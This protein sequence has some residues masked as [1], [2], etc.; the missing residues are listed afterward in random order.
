MNT[1]EISNQSCP[2]KV[3]SSNSTVDQP[4]CWTINWTYEEENPK[5]F[6]WL[7]FWK[8]ILGW[9][10]VGRNLNLAWK[11]IW[12]YHQEREVNILPTEAKCCQPNFSPDSSC[13]VRIWRRKKLFHRWDYG[14]TKNLRI[15]CQLWW[16]LVNNMKRIMQKV[17]WNWLIKFH[18]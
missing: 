5:L 4:S 6:I 13:K 3:C 7:W 17:R 11:L 12:W 14:W 10:V 15:G 1:I 8:N 2:A 18:K 9:I 16:K